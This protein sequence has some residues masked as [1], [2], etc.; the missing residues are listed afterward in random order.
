MWL[1]VIFFSFLF[2]SP[3]ENVIEK[4]GNNG[5]KKK[6]DRLITFFLKMG[7]ASF[8]KGGNENCGVEIRKH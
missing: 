5:E 1:G 3:S 2:Y 6:L 8:T 4:R 7:R